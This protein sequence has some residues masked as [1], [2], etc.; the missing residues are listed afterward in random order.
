MKIVAC[1]RASSNSMY[2]FM[3]HTVACSTEYRVILTGFD[4]VWQNL[5][6]S[7]ETQ[8][9]WIPYTEPSTQP[10]GQE[11]CVVMFT[12]SVKAAPDHWL[13]YHRAAVCQCSRCRLNGNTGWRGSTSLKMIKCTNEQFRYILYMFA[14]ACADVDIVQIASNIHFVGNY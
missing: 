3:N 10:Q 9:I 2:Q 5:S 13:L 11:F 1:A 8:L 6:T 7:C 4:G 12:C 14:Y